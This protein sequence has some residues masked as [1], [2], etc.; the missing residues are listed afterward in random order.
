MNCDHIR[1][2]MLEIS[3]AQSL[4]RDQFYS[5]CTS[6]CNRDE[7]EIQ[8]IIHQSFADAQE[9]LQFS[10]RHE[11][12][13]KRNPLMQHH[14]QDVTPKSRGAQDDNT[15]YEV[16]QLISFTP[17][18]LPVFP[19]FRNNQLHS[20][21]TPERKSSESKVDVRHVG[22]CCTERSDVDVDSK[23]KCF[24]NEDLANDPTHC[25]VA[26]RASEK[27]SPKELSGASSNLLVCDK[28]GEH[29]ANQ[30][31]SCCSYNK[32]KTINRRMFCIHQIVLL[33]Y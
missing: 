1:Q 14:T 28:G 10:R 25:A 24:K 21:P 2:E 22:T 18:T 31:L 6:R 16:A 26:S 13:P 30:R 4:L 20:N 29:T 19:G 23:V 11:C 9:P 8:L 17:L 7:A 3:Q 27:K 5:L 33:R 12:S 32:T 15:A